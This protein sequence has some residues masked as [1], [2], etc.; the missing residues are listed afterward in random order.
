[1]V[2]Y[3]DPLPARKAEA[4]Q[5]ETEQC[6]RRGLRHAGRALPD[7]VVVVI[8]VLFIRRKEQVHGRSVE[9][10]V[11]PASENRLH[12]TLHSVAPKL[13]TNELP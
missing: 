13:N 8:A 2:G 1:M 6:Q 3:L 5:A 12:S 4:N 10:A 7:Q 9:Y 11:K